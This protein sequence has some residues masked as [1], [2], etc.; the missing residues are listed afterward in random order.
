V[1]HHTVHHCQLPQHSDQLK[2][3][4]NP[5]TRKRAIIGMEN[6]LTINEAVLDEILV[7]RREL[8]SLLGYPTW[9][10]YVIEEKVGQVIRPM[11]VLKAILQMAKTAQTVF[12][13]AV[14]SYRN[15]N[16]TQ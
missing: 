9:A 12:E 16:N 7:L 11:I 13:V 15:A 4:I 1:S 3:A 6:R 14:P 8:A 10:D 2:F 5:E